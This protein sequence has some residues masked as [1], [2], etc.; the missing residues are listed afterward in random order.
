MENYYEIIMKNGLSLIAFTNKEGFCEFSINGND[1][2][3]F[4]GK[5]ENENSVNLSV[6][7]GQETNPGDEETDVLID[8]EFTVL[9]IRT[10]NL[11]KLKGEKKGEIEKGKAMGMAGRE[12]EDMCDTWNHHNFCAHQGGV[13]TPCGWL[14]GASR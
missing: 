3:I 11:K 14:F 5:A 13:K 12:K 8:H 6:S 9:S 10:L 2:F 1:F 4:S 7:A